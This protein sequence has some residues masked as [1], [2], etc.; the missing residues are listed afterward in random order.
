M[1]ISRNIVGDIQR[2]ANYI[3]YALLIS[4]QFMISLVD[5]VPSLRA[6]VTKA[7]VAGNSIQFEAGEMKIITD[8]IE[9]R[10]LRVAT[11]TTF[12]VPYCKK[13]LPANPGKKIL[14]L[15]GLPI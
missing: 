2:S 3:G 8:S 11:V 13:H 9:S 4:R 6:N 7:R 15:Q 5:E 12:Q 10:F 1:L 14:H